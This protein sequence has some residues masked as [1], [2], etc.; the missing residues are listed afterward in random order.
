MIGWS[1]HE[2]QNNVY[3]VSIAYSKGARIFERHIGIN[4]NNKYKIK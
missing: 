1:T 3:P 4:T 2:D